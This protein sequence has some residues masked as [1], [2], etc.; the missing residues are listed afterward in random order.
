MVTVHLIDGF[1]QDHL[2]A[3]RANQF[4]LDAGQVDVSG[5]ERGSVTDLD[6]YIAN[7]RGAGE[8]VVQAG[9]TVVKF[10]TEVKGEMRLGIQIN[11]QHAVSGPRQRGGKVGRR[12][13]FPNA[14][15]LIDDSDPSHCFSST[16]V[17]RPRPRN[18]NEMGPPET[19]R[20]AVLVR[21]PSKN[22]G[23]S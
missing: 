13:G 14:S 12:C 2:A 10:R 19:H 7:R 21:R 15:L 6:R 16:Q 9:L 5:D 4:R 17:Y 8:Y 3:G 18:G 20:V 1:T 11:Q 22:N 23:F